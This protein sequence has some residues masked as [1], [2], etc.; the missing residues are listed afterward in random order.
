M[1]QVSVQ[2]LGSGAEGRPEPGGTVPSP[3]EP[4]QL[5]EDSLWLQNQSVPLTAQIYTRSIKTRLLLVKRTKTKG[6]ILSEKA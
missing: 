5:V 3:W 1:F 2:S 6:E 4:S